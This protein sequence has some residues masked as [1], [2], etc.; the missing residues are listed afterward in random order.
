[1]ENSQFN[2]EII[3]Q[4]NEKFELFQYNLNNFYLFYITEKT[5]DSR[6][7]DL[8]KD[9]IKKYMF[10]IN[11]NLISIFNIINN[12]ITDT[13]CNLSQL[14]NQ[15]KELKE[16]LKILEKYINE[17]KEILDVLIY[18]ENS[19]YTIVSNISRLYIELINLIL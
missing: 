10:L 17:K 8:I 9:Q 6:R 4:F 18:Y 12:I 1:M 5:F 16:Q 13:D 15:S 7:I 11:N 14:L 3:T 2:Q 19:V